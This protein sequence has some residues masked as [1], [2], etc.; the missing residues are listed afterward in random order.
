MKH[1]IAVLML[2]I[3]V[4]GA[5]CTKSTPGGPGASLPPA[6]QASVG[7]TADSF[8]LDMPMMSTKLAQGETKAFA[9]G[10]KRGKNIDQDVTLMFNDLPKGVSIDPANSVIKHGDMDAKMTLKATDDAALGD[11]TVKVMGHPATGPD[12]TSDLK[13]TVDKK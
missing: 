13:I 2:G 7:Q 1:L 12:A 11:F 10:I 3:V 6:E 8:S 9:I 5:G 4:G